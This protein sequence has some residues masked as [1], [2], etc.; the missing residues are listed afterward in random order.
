MVDYVQV[1]VGPSLQDRNLS[2]SIRPNP[3]GSQALAGKVQSEGM[4]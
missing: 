1:P 4:H 2:T 3:V